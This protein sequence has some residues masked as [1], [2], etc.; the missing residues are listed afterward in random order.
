[1]RLALIAAAIVSLLVS[2]L[3]EWKT[4]YCRPESLCGL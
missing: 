1:M 3:D 2:G 4:R